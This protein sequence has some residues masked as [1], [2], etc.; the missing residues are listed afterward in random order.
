MEAALCCGR[1]DP[2]RDDVIHTQLVLR[3]AVVHAL[4][5][6]DLFQIMNVHVPYFTDTA[7]FERAHNQF[8]IE[9]YRQTAKLITT[10]SQDMLKQSEKRCVAEI[11]KA[12]FNKKRKVSLLMLY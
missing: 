7:L 2:T 9:K 12:I 4:R 6:Y 3:S 11:I 8:G 10:Q 5:L 1:R